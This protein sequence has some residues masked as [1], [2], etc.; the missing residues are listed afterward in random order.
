MSP[1]RRPTDVLAPV[2]DAVMAPLESGG[3]AA[4]RK[5]LLSRASGVVLDVGAGTGA[6]L[7]HYRGVERVVALEP[8]GPLRRRLSRRA[9]AAPFPIEVLDGTIEEAPLAPRS[10]DTVVCTLVLCS[11]DDPQRAVDR[12]AELVKVDGQ[13]LFLEH[14]A[15]ARG[16]AARAQS[17]LR[18][19]WRRIAGG[20]DLRR[21]TPALLR[22]S[23]LPV[24]EL[25]RFR[26]GRGWPVMAACCAGVARPRSA[27]ASAGA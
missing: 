18:R 26:I 11:V 4:R 24:T 6:N 17:A 2:Y 19:P 16:V 10:F 14:V 15:C 3:L 8:T 22:A 12:I 9:E 1:V 25:D 13:V 27:F 5:R 20:C 7:P 23:G 21:D